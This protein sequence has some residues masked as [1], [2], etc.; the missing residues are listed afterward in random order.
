MEENTTMES[1]DVEQLQHNLIQLSQENM[2][3]KN[4]NRVLN[5]KLQA[6]DFAGI[7][8]NFLFKI[9]QFK[10]FFTPE[11]CV[12]AHDDI[13]DLM[14]TEEQEPEEEVTE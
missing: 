13:I 5:Q 14:F 8:L 7:R 1:I 10:D 11:E 3:L 6:I 4:M 12:K 9:A 2:T